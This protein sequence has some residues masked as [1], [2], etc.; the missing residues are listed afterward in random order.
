MQSAAVSTL[1]KH[2]YNLISGALKRPGVRF[3]VYDI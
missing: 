1:V 3:Y 2:G